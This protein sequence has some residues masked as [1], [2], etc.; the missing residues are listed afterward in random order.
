MYQN[1]VRDEKLRKEVL[2]SYFFRA[3]KYTNV[4]KIFSQALLSISSKENYKTFTKNP[5][6]SLLHCINNI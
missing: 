2:V 5:L 1:L 6:A 4:I 3:D